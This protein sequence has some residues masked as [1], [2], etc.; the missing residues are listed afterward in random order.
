MRAH[1]KQ[2]QLKLEGINL[3]G[4]HFVGVAVAGFDGY[5]AVFDIQDAVVADS[6]VVGVASKVFEDLLWGRRRDVWRRRST[7]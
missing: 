6:D 5:E 7:R 4:D 1:K 3:D 2:I